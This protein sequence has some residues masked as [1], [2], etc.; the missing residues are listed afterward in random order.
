MPLNNPFTGIWLI[1][2]N[3][4][5]GIVKSIDKNVL[6]VWGMDITSMVVDMA[7]KNRKS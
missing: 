7:F 1:E 5:F 4:Y 6:C 3:H 2:K